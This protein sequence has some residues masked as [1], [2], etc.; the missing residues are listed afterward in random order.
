MPVI[1]GWESAFDTAA[2]QYDQWR[3]EYV[4]PL[5]QDLF[6]YHPIDPSSRV[7]EI[8]IGAG[9]ATRPFLDTG[10]TLTAV[11]LGKNLAVLVRQKFGGYR[12]FSVVAMP[13]QEYDCPNASLDCIYSASA[14]HWIPEE[15][16]YSKV[17]R[18]LKPG[19][20]FA[21][22]ANHPYYQQGQEGLFADIQKVYSEFMP[23]SKPSPEYGEEDA[24]RRADIALQYGFE[25]ARYFLYH[26]T[27]TYSSR[28]Y[29][30][31]IATYSDHI[32]LEQGKREGLT[33]GIQAAIDAHGG[34]ITLF[35]TIDLQLARKP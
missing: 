16:G 31:L 20:V 26:R 9:Q 17:F 14:F 29:L 10:C 8:G 12:N 18:L 28:E 24:K 34:I 13:F 11:E 2:S 6:A 7:L 22:F 4:A 19:G 5:Y 35:D 33:N 30:S 1:P 32:A 3:P 21:R 27:R 15:L 23:H 25:D